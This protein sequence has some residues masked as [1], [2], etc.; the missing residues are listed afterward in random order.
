[1][2]DNYLTASHLDNQENQ[3]SR[4]PPNSKLLM[5]I[6]HAHSNYFPSLPPGF[7]HQLV[8]TLEKPDLP[9]NVFQ[10]A[11]SRRPPCCVSNA[12]RWKVAALRM[13]RS[14]CAPST[15]LCRLS[16]LTEALLSVAAVAAGWTLAGLHPE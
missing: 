1:M 13:E 10:A 16:E 11:S 14:R 5:L 8:A 9:P 6:N 7:C 15:L 12:C 3:L 4:E 2:W